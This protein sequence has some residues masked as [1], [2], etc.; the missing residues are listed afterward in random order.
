MVPVIAFTLTNFISNFSIYVQYCNHSYGML[1]II[2]YIPHI[3]LCNG[4]T[5]LFKM[6]EVLCKKIRQCIYT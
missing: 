1:G 5:V 6:S 3:T 4:D 2:Q